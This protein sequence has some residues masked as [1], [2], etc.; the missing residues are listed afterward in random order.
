MGISTHPLNESA[1]VL[2]AEITGYMSQRHEM[3][4][5]L[6][7]THELDR[8]RMLDV[9]AS[10]G[11]DS[12]SFTGGF[13][14]DLSLLREDVYQPRIS[15]KPYMQYTKFEDSKE[16]ILGLAPSLRK[17]FSIQGEEFFPYMAVPVGIK[18]DNES[19]EFVYYASLTLGA[20]M[21][22][23][24]ANTDQLL[25]SL[26]GNMNMGA[27]SDYLGCLVSWVWN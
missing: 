19:D 17:G 14:M 11:Q 24:G 9:T 12:R 21:R 6:R 3:G 20:S 1:K 7:Y 16:S 8:Y 26:E 23:P 13:G 2:S 25:L 15:L 10:G 4:M 22:F 5:G 27:S 18:L